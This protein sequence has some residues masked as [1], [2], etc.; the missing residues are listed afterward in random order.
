MIAPLEMTN[1]RMENG[2]WTYDAVKRGTTANS[3]M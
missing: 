2:T 3:P 1:F